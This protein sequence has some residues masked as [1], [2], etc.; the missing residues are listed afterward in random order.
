M[1]KFDIKYTTMSLGNYKLEAIFPC[2][3]TNYVF[4]DAPITMNDDDPVLAIFKSKIE[5]EYDVVHKNCKKN[6]ECTNN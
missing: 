1:N 5:Y 6:M 2:G 4:L 3:S